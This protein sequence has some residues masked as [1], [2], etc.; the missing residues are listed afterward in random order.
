MPSGSRPRRT[1][2][3]DLRPSGRWPEDLVLLDFPK[4][5][6]SR[7]SAEDREP[8]VRV[9]EVRE[10]ESAEAGE[11]HPR[12]PNDEVIFRSAAPSAISNVEVEGL[13]AP[14]REDG[15]RI[16]EG[17]GI[18]RTQFE[19]PRELRGEP[20]VGPSIDLLPQKCRSLA[21]RPSC[22]PPRCSARNI[23]SSHV[24]VRSSWRTR[25]VLPS[26]PLSLKYR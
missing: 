9:S 2:P 7:Q 24:V 23:V 4:A 16:V 20:R 13:A 10:V 3:A 5:L 21:L 1:L 15:D 26:S 14:L 17:T 11:R 6:S 22:H 8:L 18:L 19:E 25:Y 12:A